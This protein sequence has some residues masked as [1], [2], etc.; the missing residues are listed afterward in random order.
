[1]RLGLFGHSAR[2]ESRAVAAGAHAL[3]WEVVW[4]R[5]EV[6]TEDQYEPF[7]VIATFGLRAH[8]GR[9]A[10]HYKERGT[11]VLV[12]DLPA[13]RLPGYFALW[14]NEINALPPVA[15]HDRLD[16]VTF[17]S[18]PMGDGILICGQKGGDQAHGLSSAEMR[19]WAAQALWQVRAR[20]PG[21]RIVWRPHPQE[22]FYVD[23]AEPENPTSRSLE[24][25]LR[26]GEFFA[27]VTHN[28]TCGVHA[29]LDGLPVYADP[30]AFYACVAQRDRYPSQAVTPELP[31]D[32]QLRRFFARV[33][34][35]Q[36]T[37]E[38]IATGVP[39]EAALAPLDTDEEDDLGA[40]G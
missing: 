23:G 35:S 28:S 33:M 26:S 32:N 14:L 21:R 10:A 6:W 22:T 17:K 19:A 37:L 25:A 38:E 29:L 2:S 7:D 4:Q 8:S 16:R 24:G 27:V 13:L 34:Y 12:L 18:A 36:W 39:I 9:V 30:D 5:H 31:T 15:P 11:P 3:G 40:H 1:M 20:N